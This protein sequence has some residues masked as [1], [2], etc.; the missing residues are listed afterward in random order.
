M[1]ERPL[2]K[3]PTVEKP[4][5]AISAPCAK[6]CAIQAISCKSLKTKEDKQRRDFGAKRKKLF[7]YSHLTPEPTEFSTVFSTVGA[8]TSSAEFSG[9]FRTSRNRFHFQERKPDSRTVGENRAF[10]ALGRSG[11]ANAPSMKNQGQTEGDPGLV[12]KKIGQIVFDFPRV[13]LVGP[14]QPPGK[15]SDVSVDDDT[16]RFSKSVAENDVCGLPSHAWKRHEV[17]HPIGHDPAVTFDERTADP[18]EGTGFG[19]V[20][21]AGANDVL[22]LPWRGSGV[23]GGRS[24]PLEQGRR[25]PVDSKVG[26]LRRQDG[27]HQELERVGMIEGTDRARVSPDQGRKSFFG[28]SFCGVLFLH[29]DDSM[30][31]EAGRGPGRARKK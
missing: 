3:K 25:D 23:I 15:A 14:S 12:W 4:L 20:K 18:S 16:F 7:P 27:G 26:R 22:E 30:V 8:E 11:S 29:R 17:F 6:R 24:K 28:P 5:S 1:L 19:I 10:C 9:S 2:D 13:E 31:G 21:S